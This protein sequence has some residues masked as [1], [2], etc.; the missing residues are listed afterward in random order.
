MKQV[1]EH[2]QGEVWGRSSEE[3]VH[4]VIWLADCKFRDVAQLVAR[5]IRD[6]EVVGSN[7]AIPTY[8][9]IAQLGERLPYKEKVEGSSPPVGTKITEVRCGATLSFVSLV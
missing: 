8:T 6:E 1:G 4:I 7:P 3:T 9:D 2:H 5:F